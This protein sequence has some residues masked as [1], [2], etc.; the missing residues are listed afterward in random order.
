MTTT[1]R[2]PLERGEEALVAMLTYRRPA[3]GPTEQAFIERFLLPLPGIQQDTF[4]NLWLTIARPDGTLSPILWSSHTDSVH[5]LEGRQEL[6]VCPNTRTVTVADAGKA[7]K[8]FSNCLG[9]DCA[10]GVWIMREMILA[11]VPGTYVFHRDEEAGGGGSNWVL[12]E[13]PQWL[14]GFQFAVAFDRKGYGD[15]VTH[16]G[17]RTASDAFARSV[18]AILGGKYEPDPTGV[19]TDTAV[20]AGVIPECSNISV[21]YFGQHGPAEMQDVPF[22]LALRDTVI[23][24]DWSTLVCE[25]DP[26][27]PDPAD[28]PWRGWDRYADSWRGPD[29]RDFNW[30]PP[31]GRAD[32]GS[33]ARFIRDHPDVVAD[34]LDGLGVSVDDLYDHAV[35][36]ALAH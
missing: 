21:G 32:H 28:D 6:E 15:V 31:S 36:C 2:P 23:A 19:F 3:F 34:Y 8:G 10:A 13:N 33:L 35:G 14:D 20:Y 30:S 11:G 27:Q 22:L 18:A 1:Q 9:A 4:G 29:V 24:A 12:R 26:S 25:R 5:R 7:S 17:Q 16:Q